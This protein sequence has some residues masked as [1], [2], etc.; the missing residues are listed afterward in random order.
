M[1]FNVIPMA[2][3]EGGK[4]GEVFG[5]MPE[6]RGFKSIRTKRKFSGRFNVILKLFIPSPEGDSDF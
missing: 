3:S 6:S 1:N 5:Q 4:N 2:L